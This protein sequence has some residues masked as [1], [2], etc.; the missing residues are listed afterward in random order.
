M[1]DQ[2]FVLVVIRPKKMDD[3]DRVEKNLVDIDLDYQHDFKNHE[4]I[5]H[6]NLTLPKFKIES[7][8]DFTEHLKQVSI[9]KCYMYHF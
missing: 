7:T 4:N 1:Q 8:I 3:L 2:D 9:Q 6:T 5:R